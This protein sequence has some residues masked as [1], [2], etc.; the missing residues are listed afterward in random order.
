MAAELIDA[1]STADD[2]SEIGCMVITGSLKAFAAG[3]DIKEKTNRPYSEMYAADWFGQWE[4]FTAVRK[5]MIAA[6]AGCRSLQLI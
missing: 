1:T 5:P 4:R 3:A 6:V 2:M